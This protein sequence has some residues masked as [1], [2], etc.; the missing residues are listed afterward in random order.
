MECTTAFSLESGKDL[1]GLPARREGCRIEADR[2]RHVLST[3][4]V[5]QV[6]VREK[7]GVPPP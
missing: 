4:T 5:E 3:S 6:P 2:E 7:A 1:S